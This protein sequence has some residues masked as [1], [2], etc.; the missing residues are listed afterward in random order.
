MW[1]LFRLSR[2]LQRMPSKRRLLSGVMSHSM[3]YAI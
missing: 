1:D 3:E 2:P